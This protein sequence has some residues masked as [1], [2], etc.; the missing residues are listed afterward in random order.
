[1]SGNLFFFLNNILKSTYNTFPK[2]GARSHYTTGSCSPY[3]QAA[4]AFSVPALFY[5]CIC[6]GL[7]SRVSLTLSFFSPA[8]PKTPCGCTVGDANISQEKKSAKSP[9]SCSFTL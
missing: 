5:V 8:P 9:N 7:D 1:M 3:V 2:V 4:A 6:V